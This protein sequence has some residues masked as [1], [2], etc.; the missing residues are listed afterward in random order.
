MTY[1]DDLTMN[2]RLAL[3]EIGR[4]RRPKFPNR[5]SGGVRTT[6]ALQRRGLV[7]YV[8]GYVVLTKA[9]RERLGSSI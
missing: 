4:T 6:D 3:L 7:V 9:G 2:M 8:E 5:I 1:T